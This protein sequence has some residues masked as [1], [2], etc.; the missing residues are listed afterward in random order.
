MPKGT[1]TA[2]T[3]KMANNL[4]KL[5]PEE[6]NF[7]L[8]LLASP[9][10]SL[11]EAAKKAGYD[12]PK[13]TGRRLFKRKIIKELIALEVK[14][15]EER[16]RLK[17]DDVL[18]YTREALFLNPLE[19][20]IASN[21]GKGFMVRDLSDIPPEYGRFIEGLEQKVITTPDGDTITYYKIK[22]ISKAV[23]LPLAMK[24]LGLLESTKDQGTTVNVNLNWSDMKPKGSLK[25][26][27]I[28]DPIEQ[29]LLEVE[30][31]VIEE[32]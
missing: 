28:V 24:H 5:L 9:T 4:D 12:N 8:E 15:R 29:K 21:D 25:E 3:K 23:I 7:V 19:F 16:T 31:Q 30:S 20:C 1:K 2:I 6:R 26:A 32:E 18:E 17:A 14:K 27:T 22:F 10:F 13:R 11:E